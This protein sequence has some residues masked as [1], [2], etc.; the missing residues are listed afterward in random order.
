MYKTAY[1]TLIQDFLPK[2]LYLLTFDYI[3]INDDEL[4]H[5]KRFNLNTVHDSQCSKKK[6]KKIIN[7]KSNEF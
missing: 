5:I 2:D 4:H 7:S 3:N 1:L 6:L